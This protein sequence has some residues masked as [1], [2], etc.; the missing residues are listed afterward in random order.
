[1]D[2]IS[3][4]MFLALAS[5]VVGGMTKVGEEVIVNAY[6]ALN[7]AIKFVCGVDSKVVKAI[8]EVEQNPTSKSRKGVV[9]E[10]VQ[11][12]KLDQN[13]EIAALAKQLLEAI[14]KSPK[15]VAA[16]GVDLKHIKGIALK[17]DDVIATGG[18]VII[19]D[20]ELT[21]DITI[22]KVRAGFDPKAHPSA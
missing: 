7:D 6:N 12:A 3:A 22:T 8:A 20:A 15:A 21:G 4:T 9:E 18:G 13:P 19:N 1:M 11:A 10:E 5:G 16:I 17:I 2:P 14:E